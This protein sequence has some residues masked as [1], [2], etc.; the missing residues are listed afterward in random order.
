MIRV[1]DLMQREVFTVAPDETVDRVYFLLH[2]EKIRHLPVV[3][4]GKVVGMVSD[5]DLYK[6]MGPKSRSRLIEGSADGTQLR[7]VPRSARHIM[8]RGVLT[9]APDAAA[10]EAA[11]IMAKKRI[12]ALPVVDGARLV[13]IVTA[14]D[15]LLAFARFVASHES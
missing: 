9:I 8:R 7:V 1:R 13:G 2:Y 4:K 3:E 11:T 6:A 5:R 15:L 14:T 12:G 10:A